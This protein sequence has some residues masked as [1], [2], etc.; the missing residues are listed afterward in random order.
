MQ[1]LY[2]NPFSPRQLIS[3]KI[4]L[5]LSTQNVLFSNENKVNDHT[6]HFI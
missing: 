5:T 3:M 4:L 1:P 6:Q 2:I